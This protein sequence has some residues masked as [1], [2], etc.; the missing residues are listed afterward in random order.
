VRH[1]SGGLGREDSSCG[2]GNA[3]QMKQEGRPNIGAE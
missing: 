3:F 2:G 1:V